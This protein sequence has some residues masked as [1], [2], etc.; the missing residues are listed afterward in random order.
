MQVALITVEGVLAQGDDLK[1]ALPYKWSIPLYEG[2]RSQ[3]RTV[4]LTRSDQ[5]TARWWLRREGLHSWSGVLTWN[6]FLS[7]EDWRID[8]IRD[9]LA[10][11]WEIAFLLD[12]DRDVTTVAQSMGVLTLTIGRPLTHP[13]WKPEGHGFRSWDDVTGTVE[14]RL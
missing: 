4:A 12:N 9:F 11:A 8:Q 5:E 2:I 3:F 6:Q 14:S 10:N 7:W 1:S 13:G